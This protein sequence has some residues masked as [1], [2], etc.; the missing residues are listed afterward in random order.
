MGTG[1]RADDRLA[2]YSSK[3]PSLGDDVVKPDL[4]APGN[5]VVSILASKTATLATEYPA[6]LI[7]TSYYDSK[8]NSGK[9]TYYFALSGTSMPA[10]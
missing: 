7:P 9:S 4:V 5:Q 3:G 6:G 1:N 10:W 8:G 2:S